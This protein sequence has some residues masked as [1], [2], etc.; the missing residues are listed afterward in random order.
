MRD[1]YIP[2]D[3]H[4][5]INT[6]SSPLSTTIALRT[7]IALSACHAELCTDFP[8]SIKKQPD[9]VSLLDLHL[10]RRDIRPVMKDKRNDDFCRFNGILEGEEFLT[11]GI[12]GFSFR[13]KCCFRLGLG[14]WVCGWVCD[15]LAPSSFAGTLRYGFFF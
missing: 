15:N 6:N 5:I 8:T 12:S 7:T 10:A 11:E 14:W 3:K 9:M 4:Q 1:N 2:P 13:F